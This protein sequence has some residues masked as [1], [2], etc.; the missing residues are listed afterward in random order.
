MNTASDKETRRIKRFSLALPVRVESRADEN[1]SWNEI[2]R[3][4]DI[5]AFGA[6][7]NLKRSVKRG[8]LIQMTMPLPRQMRCYDFVEPQYKIWGLVRSCVVKSSPAAAVQNGEYSIGVAFVG[9]TPPLSYFDNPNKLYELSHQGKTGN[10]WKVVEIGIDGDGNA[11]PKDVRRHSRLSLPTDIF[12]EKL[13]ADGNITA[14]EATVTENLSLSGAAIFSTLT[15]EVGEFVRVRCDSYGVSII[16]VVR[17]SRIGQDGIP[18]LHVEFID[19]L[20]PLE[21]LE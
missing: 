8:R 20:F 9:K 7:F 1:M 13:D 18:R 5:S 15:A 4:T 12:L 14:S 16:S 3:L 17:G 10:L 19:R 21:G 6:G 2:T 11:L